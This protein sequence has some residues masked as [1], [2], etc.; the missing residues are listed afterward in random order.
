MKIMRDSIIRDYEISVRGQKHNIIVTATMDGF[1]MN[2]NKTYLIQ[3]WTK[4]DGH[5]WHPK[6]KGY[7]D[8]QDKKYKIQVDN[9]IHNI[10]FFISQFEKHLNS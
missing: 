2:G 7:R 8:R 1:D 10:D 4:I 6:I 9:L 5:I 3:V